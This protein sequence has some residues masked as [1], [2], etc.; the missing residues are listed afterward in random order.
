MRLEHL[1][2]GPPCRTGQTAKNWRVATAAIDVLSEVYF[3]TLFQIKIMEVFLEWGVERLVAGDRYCPYPTQHQEKRVSSPSPISSWNHSEHLVWNH[4][5]IRFEVK[6]ISGWSRTHSIDNALCNHF[7]SLGVRLHFLPIPATNPRYGCH[8]FH[9]IPIISF[10]KM[11]PMGRYTRK[12]TLKSG[13]L[14][15]MLV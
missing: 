15:T 13:L 4:R 12:L 6:I 11:P 2:S 7:V 10:W 3:I 5:H 9:R 1:S 8:Y 14:W